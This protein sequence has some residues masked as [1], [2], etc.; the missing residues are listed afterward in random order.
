[1]LVGVEVVAMA[2]NS[3]NNSSSTVVMAS[4]SS[5]SSKQPTK[6]RSS[7]S[8]PTKSQYSSNKLT[9][10]LRPPPLPM[11]SCLLATQG[12]G[13][14]SWTKIAEN[15][16]TGIVRLENLLGIPRFS[17]LGSWLL[18]SLSISLLPLSLLPLLTGNKFIV[19]GV[20]TRQLFFITHSPN[21]LADRK[22]KKKKVLCRRRCIRNDYSIYNTISKIIV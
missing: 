3:N 22:K 20:V 13:N 7:S 4:S 5:S 8:K 11:A 10:S 17:C 1:M 12:R 2:S 16:S 21:K 14:P 18:S 15:T 9:K 6:S 19:A